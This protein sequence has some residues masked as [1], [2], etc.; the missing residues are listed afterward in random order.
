VKQQNKQQRTQPQTPIKEQMQNNQETSVRPKEEVVVK[1]EFLPSKENEFIPK[2][3]RPVRMEHGGS[4]IA[5]GTYLPKTDKA[6]PQ[7]EQQNNSQLTEQKQDRRGAR[8]G[9][10]RGGNGRGRGNYRKENEPKIPEQEFDFESANAKLD[11]K[12][13]LNEMRERKINEMSDKIQGISLQGGESFYD[14]K[15]SFFDNISRDLKDEPDNERRSKISEEKKLNLETFGS[16]GFFGPR[17]NFRGRGGRGR[18]RG[19][20]FVK[21]VEN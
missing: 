17:N 12:D 16:T 10:K 8:R 6:T 1:K 2:K 5:V 20:R 15:R 14:K 19:G 11:K 9:A 18:G 21:N 3:E 4:P 7:K 13:L